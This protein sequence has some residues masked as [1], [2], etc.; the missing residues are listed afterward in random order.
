MI[1]PVGNVQIENQCR[2]QAIDIGPHGTHFGRVCLEP[3]PI[4]VE[5]LCCGAPALI[6]RAALVRTIGGRRALMSVSI[7]DRDEN[8]FCPIQ[9]MIL[10]AQR[11]VAQEH[12]AG[13]FSV[14][15]SGM[16]ASLRK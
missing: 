11:D 8:K 5:I 6:G 14:D 12:H 10:P 4:E 13:V 7:E 2:I 3:I 15:F 1:D 16:N 9:K